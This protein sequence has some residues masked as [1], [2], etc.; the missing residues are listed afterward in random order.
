MA[1]INVWAGLQ[2]VR[3]R[4]GRNAKVVVEFR[5][6]E[7]VFNPDQRA[8]ARQLATTLTEVFRAYMLDGRW[9][10]GR[11]L[12]PVAAATGARREYRVL[13]AQRPRE[14]QEARRFDRRFATKKLGTQYPEA[15]VSGRNLVGLESGTLAKS[16][17]VAPAAGKGVR[18]FVADVRGKL[19][20][21]GSSAW[22]RV[23]RAMKG[24]GR[25]DGVF[26]DPKVQAA[27]VDAWKACWLMNGKRLGGELLRTFELL[28]GIANEAE[29]LAE[30][31]SDGA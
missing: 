31:D 11:P 3:N 17:A 15:S 7:L 30:T 24:L 18:I 26:D 4:R 10:D 6:P 5:A 1:G 19:D 12:P 27:C 22:M 9:L 28:K 25:L 2:V 20:R 16:L 23:L 8:I 13:Q 21:S 29:Q 14:G